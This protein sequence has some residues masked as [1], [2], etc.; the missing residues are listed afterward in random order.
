[1]ASSQKTGVDTNDTAAAQATLAKV[2]APEDIR[3]GDYVTPI[4]M[5]YRNSARARNRDSHFGNQ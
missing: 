5:L 2:L 4:H 3:P 1:M